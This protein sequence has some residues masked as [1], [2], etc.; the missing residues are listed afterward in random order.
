MIDAST[1]T[2]VMNS[3]TSSAKNAPLLLDIENLSVTFGE[4]ARA[5]RAVDEVSLTIKHSEV[6]AVVGE[7]GS[8]KSVTMMA[9]MG[10]L[11]PSATVRA[12]RVMFDNKDMLSMSAK[13]KRGIIGN[14]ISMIFQNAMSCLNPSFTVEMQLGEVLRKH[15][16]LRGSAVRA[17]SLELLELVEMPDAKNRLKVYPHQLSGGMSQ[18]VMIAMAIA[19]EPKLLIADEPT[20]ALDVTV[21]AQIMDL[22]NRL[23]REKQMAMVLITHDL[24]LVAQNSRDVAVMYAGQ[25]VET[26]TVPE[27]FQN[28][29]HPYTEALLQAIPELAIGQAR[30]NSLPGVVPSQYDRPKGCLLSP[31]CPYKEAA[32]EVPPPILKTPNGKV[33]CIHADLPNLPS[34]TDSSR[35]TTLEPQI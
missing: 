29:A 1:N 34:R 22:L 31:R 27:I 33:R 16:G 6:V 2:A 28:P 11:P 23:Q 9:L 14:D 26:S 25:V 32:C 3:T 19:C 24:G 35:A 30:L 15:L 17:R 18:R 7:S 21:Q 12:K 8:G 10:L 5:F 13:E 20:T 4:G